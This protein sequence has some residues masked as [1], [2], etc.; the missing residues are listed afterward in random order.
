MGCA[1]AVDDV[2]ADRRSLAFMPFLRPEIIKLDLSLTQARPTP[3]I[4]SVVH[5][6]NAEAERTGAL[7]LAEGIES[8][9]HL[10]RARAL[11]ARYGQGWRFGRPGPLPAD[12]AASG[13]T[14][15]D[16]PPP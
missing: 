11:G 14:D 12:V 3:Q 7:V 15:A 5:A 9:H 8:D 13:P 4:A 2:G 1:I 16:P 10:M 6:V